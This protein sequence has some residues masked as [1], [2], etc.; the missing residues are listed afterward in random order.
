MLART[1]E[2][3][4]G[5]ATKRQTHP[6]A[7]APEITAPVMPRNTRPAIGD[8]APITARRGSDLGELIKG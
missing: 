6:K 8:T 4:K 5:N 1:L 3:A 7:P 2:Q